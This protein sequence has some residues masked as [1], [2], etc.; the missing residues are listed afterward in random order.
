LLVQDRPQAL[1]LVH[2]LQRVQADLHRLYEEVRQYAAPIHAHKEPCDIS[3]LIH[4]AWDALVPLRNGR[5][6]RL[7]IASEAA[8]R[9]CAVDRFQMVQALRN[10]LENSL[11]AG[12]DPVRIHVTIR[13]ERLSGRQAIQVVI[14]DNG[15][16]IPA[17]R[18]Q[19]VF[20]E[21]FT[22]KTRGTGLG[23]AIVKRIVE[24]HGGQVRVNQD[25]PTG[26]ELIVTLPRE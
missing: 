13:D 16:G 20:D 2:R 8:D 19:N 5:A 18:V 26:A 25:C 1:D 4:E 23:L 14:C 15:P 24:A 22:T 9:R 7:E 12:A 3:L 6:A 10:I 11:S 21:F 17:D